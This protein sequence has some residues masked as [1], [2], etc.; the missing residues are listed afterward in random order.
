MARTHSLRAP[1]ISSLAARSIV[2]AAL[3]FASSGCDLVDGKTA[4]SHDGARAEEGARLLADAQKAFD[5]RSYDLARQLAG[6][7]RTIG[8]RTA[9]GD[10]DA[11]LARIDEA[12][13]EL[14]ANEVAERLGQKDCVGALRELDRVKADLGRQKFVRELRQNVGDQMLEC[15]RGVLAK[16]KASGSFGKAR[17]LLAAP[18]TKAL[19]GDAAW[20]MIQAELDEAVSTALRGRIAD[21]IKLGRLAEAMKKLDGAVQAGEATAE[22]AAPALEDVRAAVTAEIASIVA[23]TVGE[24]DGR[25]ALARVDELA[26]LVHWE[27][28]TTYDTPDPHR[29]MP[30][31]V[32]RKRDVLTVWN[33]AL[34]LRMKT[35]HKADKRWTY[36]RAPVLPAEAADAE[37]R[38]KLPAATQ[39][40]VIGASRDKAL[41]ARSEPSGPL[42]IRLEKAI[43][44]IPLGRLSLVPTNDWLPPDDELVGARVWGPLR[45]HEDVLELGTVT[46]IDGKE[47]VV[48][49]LADRPAVKVPVR[50]LHAGRIAVGT[51]VMAACSAKPQR[52]TVVDVLDEDGEEPAIRVACDDGTTK[53]AALATLQTRVELLVK[54]H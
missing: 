5:R 49:P 13:A 51:R 23:R 18:A 6:R 11:L 14:W 28:D 17:T 30:D 45:P 26:A 47:A 24:R 29:T 37:P 19:L 50:A 36:G 31:E 25:E 9:R 52:A 8:T 22:Q 7:A 43:G 33:E 35:N 54:E 27:V 20:R 42:A 38:G 10:A 41:V 46:R 32:R 40:W 44:W 15:V 12:D 4:A 53:E 21:E 1:L 2:A 34:R 16:G 48:Q 3:A 39:V